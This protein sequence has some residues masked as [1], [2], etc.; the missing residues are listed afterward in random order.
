[1]ADIEIQIDLDGRLHPVGWV[2]RNMVRGTE[3]VVFE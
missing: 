3:T 2:R 1:M